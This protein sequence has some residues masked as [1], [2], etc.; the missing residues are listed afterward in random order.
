MAWSGEED[1][2]CGHDEFGAGDWEGVL[3]FAH[4]GVNGGV[5]AEGLAHGVGVEFEFLQAVVGERGGGVA[6]DFELFIVELFG[7]GG[8]GREVETGLL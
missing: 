6:E 8:L 3:D 4:D 7:D 2:R 1:V 5:Q